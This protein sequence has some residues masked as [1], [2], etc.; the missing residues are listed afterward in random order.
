MIN[1]GRGIS[2]LN[3]EETEDIFN[4][5]KSNGWQTF[6]RQILNNFRKMN[7]FKKIANF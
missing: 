5:L 2:E 7:I 4:I 1:E 3:K 6:D